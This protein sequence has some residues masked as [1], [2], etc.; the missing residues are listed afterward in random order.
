MKSLSSYYLPTLFIILLSISG[1]KERTAPTAKLLDDVATVG[2]QVKGAQ[3][4]L[5]INEQT[6][7]PIS[8]FNNGIASIPSIGKPENN[9]RVLATYHWLK[10]NG[11][12]AVW[13]GLRTVLPEDIPKGKS[14]DIQ[15]AI[16]APAMKGR[17]ILV[18]D[19]VQE[20]A[21]WFAGVGSQTANLAYVIE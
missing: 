12:V 2:I 19:L 17:Y 15:L 4:K 11:E 5:K 9:L 3:R 1:C 21:M 18:I 20:G 13:D 6:M 10:E 7:L 8:I 16:K 14:L